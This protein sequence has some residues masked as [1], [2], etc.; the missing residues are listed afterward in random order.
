M[1]TI[2]TH[3]SSYTNPQQAFKQS[4]ISY[5][6]QRTAGLAGL[7]KSLQSIGAWLQKENESQKALVAEQSATQLQ[8]YGKVDSLPTFGED[9]NTR[10][11]RDWET[12]R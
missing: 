2:P 9:F 8:M 1:A 11:D 5:S 12:F 6:D 7:S 3:S 10:Q 4:F